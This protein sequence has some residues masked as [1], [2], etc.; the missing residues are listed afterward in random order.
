MADNRLATIMLEMM[1]QQKNL[2]QA[3]ITHLEE[4]LGSEHITSS[5][6]V[7][8]SK[9]K[10]SKSEPKDPNQPKKYLTGYQIYVSEN[11]A[12]S[13]EENPNLSAREIISMLG[14]KWRESSE[15][16]KASFQEKS[17][18][19]KAIYD[20][21]MKEYSNSIITHGTANFDIG[22]VGVTPSSSATIKTKKQKLSS[23]DTSSVNV[24]SNQSAPQKAA[25]QSESV[26]TETVSKTATLAPKPPAK[27]SS[28]APKPLA[29][30]PVPV[31]AVAVIEA[32][33]PL[34]TEESEEPEPTE[35][36][37]EK[38]KKD[39]KKSKK[40]KREKHDETET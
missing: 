18:A 22:H 6:S 33:K 24:S 30:A 29:P 37:S 10:K 27:V 20:E 19:L 23:S 15:E 21:Q 7:T 8:S 35:E 31:P 11:Q 26:S 38:H 32:P 9:P 39:K 13:K 17:L 16:T 25:V 1:N 14:Q 28:S 3:Q 5:S 40:H 34:L 36:K 12:K 2:I 4:Y